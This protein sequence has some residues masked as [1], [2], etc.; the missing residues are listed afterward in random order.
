MAAQ[1]KE[2][3]EKAMSELAEEE[4]ELLQH[5]HKLSEA[6]GKVGKCSLNSL[7]TVPWNSAHVIFLCTPQ[8]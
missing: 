6:A 8:L 3:F 7:F 2:E 5:F 4:S 1:A